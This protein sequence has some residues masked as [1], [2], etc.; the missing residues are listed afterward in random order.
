[1]VEMVAR[2]GLKTT[3]VEEMDTEVGCDELV[4]AS[5]VWHTRGG[6][7]IESGLEGGVVGQRNHFIKAT[8][9]EPTVQ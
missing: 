3:A 1:M 5:F 8:A 6:K 9:A 4:Q 2:M 7:R